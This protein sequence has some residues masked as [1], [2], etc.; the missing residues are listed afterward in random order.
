MAAK[1]EITKAKDG[2]FHFHLK[3]SNGEI[4]LTSQMYAAKSS[5][6]N[7]I[8]SV[9]KN[10]PEDKRYERKETHN[11]HYMFNLRAGNHEVIGTSQGYS[12]HESRDRGIES[13]KKNAPGA[14]VH[15][16]SLASSKTPHLAT[17]QAAGSV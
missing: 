17:A 16:L 1:F 10:A 15:D 13:V 6:K 14:P 5:A 4:I 9:K 2:E 7:G 3:A 8:E 11:G 12:S